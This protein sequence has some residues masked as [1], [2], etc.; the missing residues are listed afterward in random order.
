MRVKLVTGCPEEKSPQ[1]KWKKKTIDPNSIRG[2]ATHKSACATMLAY[3]VHY[4]FGVASWN[5]D[6][7]YVG[8]P[9]LLVTIDLYHAPLTLPIQSLG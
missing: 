2:C 3:F 7:A 5:S 9:I 6:V 4:L 1:I 8:M